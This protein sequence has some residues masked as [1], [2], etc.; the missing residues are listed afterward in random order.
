MPHFIVSPSRHVIF[1]PICTRQ[2][3]APKLMQSLA[4]GLAFETW[5]ALGNSALKTDRSSR[6]IIFYWISIPF[7]DSRA[8]RLRPSFVRLINIALQ[9]AI[10][11]I[12][13]IILTIQRTPPDLRRVWLKFSHLTLEIDLRLSE[14]LISPV[15]SPK[16]YVRILGCDY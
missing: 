10:Y 1:T 3:W 15:N 5:R 8:S 13:W 6:N 9:A 16:D 7:R 4:A 12:F 2:F 14:N 11:Q